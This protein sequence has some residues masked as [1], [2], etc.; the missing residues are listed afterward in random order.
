MA[1]EL[2]EF[3]VCTVD[4]DEFIT[5]RRVLRDFK[6]AE[7]DVSNGRKGGNPSLKIRE[8]DNLGVNPR[9]KAKNQ[10]PDTRS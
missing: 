9:V 8:K 5:S 7:I 6:K 3:G 2:I 1:N 4:S 10:I